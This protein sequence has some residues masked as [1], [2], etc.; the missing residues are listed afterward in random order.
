MKRDFLLLSKFLT[1]CCPQLS[2][3]EH[4]LP[5][6]LPDPKPRAPQETWQEPLWATTCLIARVTACL[7]EGLQSTSTPPCCR[8]P[9]VPP[10]HP[11]DHLSAEA[12]GSSTPVTDQLRKIKVQNHV[13]KWI[14]IAP[15]GPWRGR[16]HHHHNHVHRARDADMP[17]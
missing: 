15:A 14:R 16:N 5:S 12:L 2:V 17:P 13:R 4:L 8:T 9:D 11:S 1:I 3:P 10:A 6:T 7:A